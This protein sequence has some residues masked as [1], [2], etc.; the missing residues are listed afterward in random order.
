M[1]KRQEFVIG[2]YT[3]SDKKSRGVSSLLLSVYEGDKLNY[4]GRAG[5]GM[6]EKD[7]KVLKQ[8]LAI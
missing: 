6:S 2:G 8:N 4:I 1:K 5:T 3:L 7:M